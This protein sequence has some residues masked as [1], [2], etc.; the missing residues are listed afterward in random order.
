LEI[1]F[2]NGLEERPFISNQMKEELKN[3]EL[4]SHFA[5]KMKL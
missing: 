3:M 4:P 1:N 5:L 2:P